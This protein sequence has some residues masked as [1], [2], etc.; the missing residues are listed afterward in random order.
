M[1]S[2]NPF[3]IVIIVSLSTITLAGAAKL[4]ASVQLD[5]MV[6]SPEIGGVHAGTTVSADVPELVTWAL[7][8]R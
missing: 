8:P 1:V 5:N 6:Q 7:S 2:I 4:A 3:G